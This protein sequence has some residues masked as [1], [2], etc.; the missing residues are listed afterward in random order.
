MISLLTIEYFDLVFEHFGSDTTLKFHGWG[1]KVVFDREGLWVEIDF[2]YFFEPIELVYIGEML[3]VI[4]DQFHYGWTLANFFVGLSANRLW[5]LF[6]P[7][8]DLVEIRNDD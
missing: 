4:N 7:L 5:L 6:G 8:C 2:F 3:H 1:K